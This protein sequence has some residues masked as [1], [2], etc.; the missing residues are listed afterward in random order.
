M[1]TAIPFQ[2]AMLQRLGYGSR[3]QVTKGQHGDMKIIIFLYVVLLFLW[4]RITKD[5]YL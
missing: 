5:A 3:G 2:T 4:A 1:A